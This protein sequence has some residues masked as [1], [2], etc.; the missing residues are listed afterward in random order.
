M[1]HS[2]DHEGG[3][4]RKHELWNPDEP[5]QYDNLGPVKHKASTSQQKSNKHMYHLN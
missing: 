4:Q 5:K 2:G 1:E 3:I